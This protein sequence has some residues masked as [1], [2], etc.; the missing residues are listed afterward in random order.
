MILLLGV[1]LSGIYGL[2]AL[3]SVFIE[4]LSVQSA[5]HPKQAKEPGF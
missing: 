1:V 5:I 2:N 4:G 3:K